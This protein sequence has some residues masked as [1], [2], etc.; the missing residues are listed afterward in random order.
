[1]ESAEN[2]TET[3]TAASPPQHNKDL[4]R[5]V[6]L[7]HQAEISELKDVALQN[8]VNHMAKC[9]ANELLPVM[10]RL[11]K[12]D[13]SGTATVFYA[14][15]AL[16]KNQVKLAQRIIDPLLAASSAP[17]TTLLLGARIYVRVGDV[18]RVRQLLGR[19]PADSPL[20]KGIREV[21]GKIEALANRK[22][23]ETKPTF[24]ARV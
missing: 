14:R 16:Q 5:L 6:D 7:L 1:M 3:G 21:E 12:W 18:G 23:P 2:N 9:Y 10:D 22:V 17:D 4:L 20:E 13:A 15:T 8:L 11:S 19:I 24:E